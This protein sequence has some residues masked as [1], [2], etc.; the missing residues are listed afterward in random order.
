MKITALLIATLLSWSA[1]AMELG[2]AKPPSQQQL[3]LLLT[4]NTIQ[5]EWDGRPFSQ[6]FAE[7]GSTRYREADGLPYRGTWSV[8]A[9]G[10][11]CSVW[12]PSLIE[13]CYDVLVKG[14]NVLWKSG[15]KIHPSVVTEGDS[16]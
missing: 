2:D 8:N 5:G 10:Q 1:L 11:Y 4:G 3:Q 13:A 12:P 16:F 7:D 14:N 9:K 6:H 15:G